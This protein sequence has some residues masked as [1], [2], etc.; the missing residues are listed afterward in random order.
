MSAGGRGL[1]PG[2]IGSPKNARYRMEHLEKLVAIRLRLDEGQSLDQISE[3]LESEEGLPM[4]SAPLMERR[5]EV[6]PRSLQLH[7][8]R[9]DYDVPSPTLMRVVRLQMTKDVTLEVAERAD[10][11]SALRELFERLKMMFHDT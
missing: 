5:H 11:Q 10:R 3:E 4:A 9:E 1:L 6:K 2:A 7:Q 8:T